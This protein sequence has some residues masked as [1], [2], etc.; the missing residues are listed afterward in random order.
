MCEIYNYFCSLSGKTKLVTDNL[1]CCR[2][3]EQMVT[4]FVIYIDMTTGS[5]KR[6]LDPVILLYLK[7]SLVPSLFFAR[8]G[9]NRLGT[10]LPE[11][12]EVVVE[13]Q[14]YL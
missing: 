14:L 10:R 9:K 12:H 8:G 5:T 1:C 2:V 3:L 6:I 4:Y 7:T 11:N 13:Y